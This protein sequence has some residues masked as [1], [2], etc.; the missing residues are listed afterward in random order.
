MSGINCKCMELLSLEAGRTGTETR[1]KELVV[2]GRPWDRIHYA[3]CDL[4]EPVGVS[5]LTMKSNLL[6]KFLKII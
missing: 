5:R 3:T 2:G 4:R 1:L 6:L